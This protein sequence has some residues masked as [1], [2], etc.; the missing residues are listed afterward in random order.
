MYRFN[1]YIDQ[2][3]TEP[4]IRVGSVLPDNAVNLAYVK[5][6]EIVSEDAVELYDYSN[7]IPE[8][9]VVVE[10]FEKILW[11]AEGRT[12]Q[13]SS[14]VSYVPIDNVLFTNYFKELD[15]GE[16]VPMYYHY[17]SRF[18][19]HE[20]NPPLTT[21]GAPNEAQRVYL[22]HNIRVHDNDSSPDGNYII[23][24]ENAGT[25]DEQ[26]YRVHVYSDFASSADKYYILEYSKWNNITQTV[27]HGFEEIYNS[28]PLFVKTE[29]DI[30]MNAPDGS[31]VYALEKVLTDDG[32][33]IFTAEDI[34]P[35]SRTEI[36]FRWRIKDHYNKY[37][38]WKSECILRQDSLYPVDYTFGGQTIYIDDGNIAKKILSQ[39]LA[40]EIAGATPEYAVEHQIWDFDT[41]SWVSDTDNK[42]QFEIDSD[43]RLLAWTAFQTGSTIDHPGMI[44][45][46]YERTPVNITIEGWL[47]PPDVTVTP[48]I[49]TNVSTES[50]GA[51][52]SS[53]LNPSLFPIYSSPTNA[54]DGK[55]PG[56]LLGVEGWFYA[57]SDESEGPPTNQ[58]TVTVDL[59][60]TIS[61]HKI[62]IV[63]GAKGNIAKAQVRKSD[64]TYVTV[65]VSL[66][67]TPYCCSGRYYEIENQDGIVE[68]ATH[69]VVTI[70]PSV[71]YTRSY[72]YKKKLWKKY[73]ADLY[74]SGFDLYEIN[75]FNYYD[76]P[77]IEHNWDTNIS[78][79]FY[80]M[81]IVPQKIDVYQLLLD[82]DMIPEGYTKANLKYKISLGDKT[83]SE[84]IHASPYVSMSALKCSAGDI[85]NWRF[86]IGRLP[87]ADNGIYFTYS[88]ITD[89]SITLTITSE[90]ETGC[91]SRMFS[92]KNGIN[93]R[94]FLM[95]FGRMG[96]DEM[97]L[98]R[99]N[100]GRMTREKRDGT[101][102]LFIDYY[103]PEYAN[104]AFYPDMPY[105][106]IVKEEAEVVD[107][108]TVA[109]NHTPLHVICDSDGNPVNLRAY[110]DIND[111]ITEIPIV[112]WN[113]YTGEIR[114]D[115]QIGYT[116]KIYVDYY[117]TQN[118][119]VYKGYGDLERGRFN[120][121]DLNPLPGHVYTD[122]DGEIRPS[123]E[124]LNKSVYFYLV[125]TYIY[126]RDTG[127]TTPPVA[128]SL[129]HKIIDR[130]INEEEAVAIIKAELETE[131]S[132]PTGATPLNTSITEGFMLLAKVHVNRPSVPSMIKVTDARRR[133]G[134][135][136]DKLSPEA[137]KAIKDPESSYIWDVGSWDGLPYPS[138]GVIEITVPQSLLKEHG[139]KFTEEDIREIINQHV[140]YGIYVFIQYDPNK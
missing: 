4:T 18:K 51:T 40:E 101:R 117:F 130:T 88:D 25:E 37:S 135:F 105:N 116:D 134:G 92:V 100:N 24:L 77:D 41:S 91:Y 107:P 38:T 119:L 102:N 125:P 68:D 36:L 28:E 54:I 33:K 39:N 123:V 44:S 49:K 90:Q 19:H 62:Q 103:L 32:Y 140:A 82:N 10:E 113:M 14:G 74:Q 13:D 129:R 136:R 70:A 95:P 84:T 110:L 85:W 132:T 121:L 64:G 50:A 118:Y 5:S 21:D 9:T 47:D 59:N 27:E 2:N 106:Y 109:V 63:M 35:L 108:V 137:I 43:S 89:T 66:V 31:N 93:G 3:N 26:L 75:A 112:N 1:D 69:L 65:P 94:I 53:D 22:G 127:E 139:G 48:V 76:P 79:G 17:V 126:N 12:V 7:N 42:V 115:R 72:V 52:I 71:W 57:R 104:Q 83:G 81:K 23:C 55:N 61:L 124:L 16:L 60:K 56:E 29:K 131:S 46:T 73:Y 99:V 114:L 20:K 11:A 8:N 45:K 128:F 86:P 6:P 122:D 97:W 15:N 98:P 111:V 78:L 120:Y 80:V 87:D 138:N 30:V 34:D 96:N 133:G 58:V 67:D